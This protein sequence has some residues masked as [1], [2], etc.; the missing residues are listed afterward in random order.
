LVHDFYR[1]FIRRSE[2]ESHYVFMGR[3][4]TVGLF[5]LSAALVFVLQTAEE[6]FYLILQIGAGTGLLYLL[7]W[8]W[9]RINGWCE[10]VA[11][12]S[13]F[14]V[15]LIFF[16]AKRQGMEIATDKQLIYTVIIT[17]ICWVATAYL[18]PQT[19]KQTLID[20]YKKV[21]PF[22]PGWKPI[23]L[24]AGISDA[25]IAEW[26]KTD[27]VTL[28]MTGWVTGTILIWA[29]LFTVGNFLYERWAYAF[30]LLAI[31]IVS[32]GVLIGVVRRLWR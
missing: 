5:I 32:G 22:G 8:F 18:G 28:A 26:N 20:F 23:Q 10:I 4:A 25:E 19:D 2:T 13:S 21:Q 31:S 1:R 16:A 24:A 29:A 14:L 6:A 9:W 27:N 17:T 11:M 12:L 15:S 30:V 3:L 7:R